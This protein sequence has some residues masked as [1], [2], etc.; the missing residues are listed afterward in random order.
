MLHGAQK[1]WDGMHLKT[2]Q[3]Q[4]NSVLPFGFKMDFESSEK[5]KV[6]ALR[7]YTHIYHHSYGS[8]TILNLSTFDE[9]MTTMF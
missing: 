7:T 4:L 6:F 3:T 1:Q 8:E 9:Q 5:E 2:R